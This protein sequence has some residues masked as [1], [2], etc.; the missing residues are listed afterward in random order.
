MSLIEYPD[1]KHTNGG[2]A[3]TERV[4]AGAAITTREYASKAAA[5]C[6]R[7]GIVLITGV[8]VLK[9]FVV[10]GLEAS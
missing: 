10:A 3:T 9:F 1:V 6:K 5:A 8:W 7:I 2:Y 4:A